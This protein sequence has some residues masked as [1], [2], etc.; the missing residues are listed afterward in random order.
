MIIITIIYW[1][2]T[3][4]HTHMQYIIREQRIVVSLRFFCRK[5][6]VRPRAHLHKK[7]EGE[8]IFQVETGMKQQHR[9]LH[10]ITSPYQIRPHL[11]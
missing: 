2:H 8:H 4:T 7:K 6:N 10:M 1:S 11:S 9:N 3:K 5:L